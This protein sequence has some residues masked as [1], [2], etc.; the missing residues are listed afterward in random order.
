MVVN[1][2]LRCV[3]SIDTVVSCLQTSNPSSPG[4][5]R[6]DIGKRPGRPSTITR[7][8][9]PPFSSRICFAVRPTVCARR[10]QK[11]PDVGAPAGVRSVKPWA[12]LLLKVPSIDSVRRPRSAGQKH[13]RSCGPPKS[14]GSLLASRYINERL[15]R[16]TAPCQRSQALIPGLLSSVRR[17]CTHS[18]RGAVY[19]S[20]TSAK[21]RPRWGGRSTTASP[22]VRD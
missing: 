18:N 12:A 22:K 11:Q 15:V 13:R 17:R 19:I 7:E 8:H 2:W 3:S 10:P 6:V 9:W 1:T 21:A 16:R 5:W 20:L 14:A 4:W